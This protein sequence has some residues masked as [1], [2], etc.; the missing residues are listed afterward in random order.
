MPKRK[1][2][3]SGA[4]A[5]AVN[6]W[7]SELGCDPMSII[8]RMARMEIPYKSG[9][10]ISGRTIVK[11]MTGDKE[12]AA[13]AK[14][15][16]ETERIN[17]EERVAKG[18]LVTIAEAEEQVWRKLLAPLKQ[19]IEFLPE[20]VA[21]LANPDDIQLAQN[22][23]RSWVEEIKRGIKEKNDHSRTSTGRAFQ[24]S[25]G[26]QNRSPG[27]GRSAHTGQRT[28]DFIRQPVSQRFKRRDRK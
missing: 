12:A 9:E 6:A 18:E 24:R 5:F 10:L 20:K 21:P 7:A 28:V 3:K 2:T 19:E 22:A 1:N 25:G 13:T 17:R 27:A 14:L 8:R 4:I 26:D 16:A 11:S 15:L 23:L